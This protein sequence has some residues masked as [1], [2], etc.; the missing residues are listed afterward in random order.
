MLLMCE[1]LS[2]NFW[3][4]NQERMVESFGAYS[5]IFFSKEEEIK[6]LIQ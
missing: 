2:T 4:K 5:G 3:K 1:G 6:V